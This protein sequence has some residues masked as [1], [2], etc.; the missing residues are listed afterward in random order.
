MPNLNNTLAS[1]R[2]RCRGFTLLEVLIALLIFSLGMMGLGGLMAASIKSNQ[3]SFMRTQATFLAQSLMD[4]MHSNV[5][6]VWR[7]QY[8][9]DH[10]GDASGTADP[11][12]VGGPCTPDE[13]AA[14]DLNVW[15]AQVNQMLPGTP[16]GTLGCSVTGGVP[17]AVTG[18]AY[19]PTVNF[20]PPYSGTCTLTLQW[21]EGVS[22]TGTQTLSWVF[23]P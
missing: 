23:Q 6:G 10:L 21:S 9:F 5:I 18:A 14:H 1:M 8:A 4:R 12:C 15:A 16:D 13:V 7:D 17:G 19:I 2:Y 20:S 3:A 11:G 22:A